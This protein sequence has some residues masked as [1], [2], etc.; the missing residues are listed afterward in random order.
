M[1]KILLVLFILC[2]LFLFGCTLGNQN[3]GDEALLTYDLSNIKFEDKAYLY[4]GNSHDLVIDGELPDGLSVTYTGNSKTEVGEY[5]VV[6]TFINNND[7]YNTPSPL[8]ATLYIMDGE[9]INISLEDQ[10]FAYDGEVHSLSLTGLLPEGINVTFE[11]NDAVNVGTYLVT[12]TFDSDKLEPLQATL[13]ITK[14]T[15]DLS[16]VSFENV[17][18][19]YDGT[20]KYIYIDGEL[21]SG[22][23][24]S[25]EGNG[26]IELGEYEVVAYFTG[27]PNNYNEIE[28][29]KATLTIVEAPTPSL[30]Y[31]EDVFYIVASGEYSVSGEFKQIRVNV[32][33]EDEGE[34]IINLEGATITNDEEAPIYIIQAEEVT[35]S[36]K[37]GTKNYVY[38][39]R[40]STDEENEVGSAAIYATCD[41]NIQGKGELTVVAKYNNGIHTKDDLKIKNLTLNV[42]APNN[43]LKG[44]DSVTIKSGTLTIISTGG[45][46]IKTTNSDISSKG[47]QRGTVTIN[48]G[49]ITLYAACDGI[50]AAYDVVIEEKD[51]VEIDL[52]IY[53]SNY[54]SYTGEIH[55]SS[56]STSTYYV[57]VSSSYTNYRYAMYLYN[58]S[59]DYKW[60]NATYYGASR[61]G[62]TTYYYYEV[63][64]PS[65]YQNYVLYAFN[66]NTTA[67]S[68]DSYVAKSGGATVNRA[69]NC[70]VVS[71]IS[72]SNIQTSWTSVQ[73][74][75]SSSSSVSTKGIK[76][77]N[78][79]SIKSGTILIKSKDDGIH[80][81]LDNELENGEKAVGNVTIDGGNITITSGDDG[82]H[83]DYKLEINGGTIN[84]LTA[85][86]GLEGN[87]ILINGGDITVYATDDGV[88]AG[89]CGTTNTPQIV[90]NGGTLDVTVGSGDTDGI[91]SNGTYLQTGGLVIT[92]KVSGNQNMAAIDA[93]STIKITGGTLI[94]LGYSPNITT[95]VAYVKWGSTSQGGFG[96]GGFGPGGYGGSSSGTSSGSISIS[97]GTYQI[98]SL[99]F[100]AN[101]T[102]DSL[103]IY[104]DTFTSGTTYTL[105]KDG[106]ATSYSASATK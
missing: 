98:G 49:T 84:V 80:A 64:V 34:V 97:S 33:E 79:I 6:A 4:D 42:T 36:A 28:P 94:A 96:P 100:E 24:V 103:A 60:V 102:Y 72:S 57:R 37:K 87:Y 16:Q 90:I 15:Y 25:Y 69:N 3:S 53:T 52:N 91:D 73:T 7:D 14:G 11:N 78:V 99:T 27:D 106:S 26:Q 40:E 9:S 85:Y 95:S 29:L 88:N 93:D 68:T 47:N 19:N 67:N 39:N 21:P 86:E 22:V 17:R 62:K 51:D 56:T 89:K 38:D 46:A 105:Y 59:D 44:N 63:N 43:A 82:I 35:I 30:E 13:T 104:S 66:S 8:K 32:P 75:S 50:D 76:A 61:N 55:T 2:P 48:G 58:D 74:S 5:E 70:L 83:A 18:V 31:G 81:N 45:D 101:A 23:S 65:N 1:K 54:S 71:S 77:D 92:R 10:T 20:E 12:A 41:L